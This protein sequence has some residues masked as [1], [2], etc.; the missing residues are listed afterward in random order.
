MI[1]WQR[2]RAIANAIIFGLVGLALVL[3]VVSVNRIADLTQAIRETQKTNTVIN[4]NSAD[5]LAT[6]HDCTD[7]TGRCYKRGQKRTANAVA[8]INRVVILAAACASGLPPD[9][10]IA[11]RQDSIQ[12][13]VI[14]RLARK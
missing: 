14:D 2:H 8:Q 9:L 4:K 13:C 10:T 5:V 7:P 1:L 11:E 12:S 6:V 3:I